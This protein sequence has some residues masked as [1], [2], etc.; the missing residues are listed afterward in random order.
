MIETDLENVKRLKKYSNLLRNYETNI[1]NGKN[2][3]SSQIS[4]VN[5][6]NKDD[7]NREIYKKVEQIKS[8]IDVLISLYGNM[9]TEARQSA[10]GISNI[11]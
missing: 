6:D 8:N 2:N 7:T 11:K 9:V 4:N 10:K 5:L 3:L 1:K